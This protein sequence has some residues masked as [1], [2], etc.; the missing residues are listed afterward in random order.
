MR[1]LA[2]AAVGLVVFAVGCE[3]KLQPSIVPFEGQGVPSQESWKS[4][5][6][7]S[8]SARITALLWAGYIAV[9]TDREYTLLGDSVHVDFFNLQGQHTSEL[10]ARRGRVNDRSRDFAAYDHVVVISDSGS[11]L[12]TDSLFWNSQTQK[13]ETDAFVEIISPHEH[14]RGQGLV[15]DQSL[16]DYRIFKVTG[17]AVVEEE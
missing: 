15:S 9:Y 4:T 2:I 11:V 13:I 12:K 8:D 14:I 5:I 17:E 3:E 10:T 1:L 6:T 7:F 16:K